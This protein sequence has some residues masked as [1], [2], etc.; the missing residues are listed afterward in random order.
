[1]KYSETIYKYMQEIKGKIEQ[2][3]QQEKGDKIKLDVLARRLKTS[4]ERYI[5]M[6]KIEEEAKIITNTLKSNNRTTITRKILQ[7][8][9]IL[10]AEGTTRLVYEYNEKI[11]KVAKSTK[12]TIKYLL[13]N[14]MYW[15]EPYENI[16]EI[17]KSYNTETVPSN[18]KEFWISQN[19]NNSRYNFLNPVTKIKKNFRIIEQEKIDCYGLV[20]LV[21]EIDE[22]GTEESDIAELMQ[23]GALNK[24]MDFTL[25]QLLSFIKDNNLDE[26]EIMLV[27]N[28]GI[29]SDGYLR[30]VDFGR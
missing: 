16:I 7:E 9:G 2:V 3:E 26:L 29:N 22:W 27:K 6:L 5:K 28:W 1:M 15:G 10:V 30:L 20:K 13:D 18:I 19:N 21:E 24:H 8:Q 14:S 11:Y 23:N 4:K 25:E 12:D 17:A